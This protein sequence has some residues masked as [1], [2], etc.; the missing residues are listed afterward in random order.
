MIFIDDYCKMEFL[1]CK[2]PPFVQSP[3][4]AGTTEGIGYNEIPED[5]IEVVFKNEADKDLKVKS[6]ES[7]E[8]NESNSSES[9]SDEKP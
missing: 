6:K 4:E 7:E 8:S 9:K 5:N 3:P 2:S 1:S